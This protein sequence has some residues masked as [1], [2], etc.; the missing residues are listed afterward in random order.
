ME[1]GSLNHFEKI[2]TVSEKL[3][4]EFLAKIAMKNDFIGSGLETIVQ[5][6]GINLMFKSIEDTHFFGMSA[7]G[8]GAKFIGI[9]TMH[10]KRIQTFTLAHEFWHFFNEITHYSIKEDERAA[11]HFAASLLLPEQK[12]RT[13]YSMYK[14][15]GWSEI[16]IL[17]IIADYSQC[18]YETVYKRFQELHLKNEM[19]TK[20]L[21]QVV[22]KDEIGN[23]NLDAEVEKK[24]I[25][26]RSYQNTQPISRLDIKEEVNEFPALKNLCREIT[27]V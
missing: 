6:Q 24:F 1:Q 20:L 8:K 17:F 27:N 15:S 2:H 5:K 13:I 26:L 25:M 10:N 4:S 18:P 11:D 9:N 23:R 21:K 16:S 12:V 19:I 3:A 22:M 14:K 7:S